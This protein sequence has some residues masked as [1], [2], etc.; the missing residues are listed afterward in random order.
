MCF[1]VIVNISQ[2]SSNFQTCG[3][4]FMMFRSFV[5]Y[6]LQFLKNTKPFLYDEWVHTYF[7]KINVGL[8]LFRSALYAHK[9][10]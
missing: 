1:L 8:Q 9:F 2:A 10:S 7:A 5:Q 6:F 3:M 4:I